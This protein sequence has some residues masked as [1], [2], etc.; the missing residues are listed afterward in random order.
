[1]L[2]IFFNN[3]LVYVNFDFFEMLDGNGCFGIGLSMVQINDSEGNFI[4]GGMLL[5]IILLEI[6]DYILFFCVFD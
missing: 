1:M 3:C 6:G 4:W 2:L 5:D